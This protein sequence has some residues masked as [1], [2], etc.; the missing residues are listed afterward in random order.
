MH[1]NKK[2]CHVRQSHI[3]AGKVAHNLPAITAGKDLPVLAL[4][5]GMLAFT[6][7]CWWCSHADTHV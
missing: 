1:F 4:V 7:Q 3:T 2:A 5:E 6:V